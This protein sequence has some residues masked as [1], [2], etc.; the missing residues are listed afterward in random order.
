MT[1]RR[2]VVAGFGTSNQTRGVLWFTPN[3][4][5]EQ[6]V[7]DADGVRRGDLKTGERAEAALEP[8]PRVE[9]H[10]GAVAEAP[11][12]LTGAG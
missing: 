5:R 9:N 2:L 10:V 7:E 3:G 4:G 1:R 11:P 8:R 12:L 6:C